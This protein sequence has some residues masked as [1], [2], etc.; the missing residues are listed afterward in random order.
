MKSAFMSTCKN[1]LII[2]YVKPLKPMI[3]SSM[4]EYFE[5]FAQTNKP[6]VI[7]KYI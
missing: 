5:G 7:Y 3:S 2:L 6:Y 4:T 1:G